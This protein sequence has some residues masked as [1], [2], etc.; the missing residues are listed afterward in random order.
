MSASDTIANRSGLLAGACWAAVALAVAVPVLAQFAAEP[1]FLSVRTE[2]CNVRA[3]PQEGAEILWKMWKYFAV[4][5]VGYRG[6][7]VRVR[8]FEGDEGWMHKSV[9]S[10]IPT[11][12]VVPKEAK[13]RESPGGK[14]VWILDR[15]YSLRVFGKKGAWLEVSDLESASGWIHESVVWGAPPPKQPARP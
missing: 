12:Q 10:D 2:R 8:D 7:W 13:L 11:V 1:E 14:V 4:E 3:A 15:G 9:V 5:V 6:A